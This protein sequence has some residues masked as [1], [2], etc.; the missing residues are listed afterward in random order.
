MPEAS[1]HPDQEYIEQM[2]RY[3]YTTA[4]QRNIDI[5]PK[6]GAERHMPATPEFSYTFRDKR[7]IKIFQKIKS[8]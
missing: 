1:K 2:P 4:S 7:I 8:K 5:I 3:T 6:P